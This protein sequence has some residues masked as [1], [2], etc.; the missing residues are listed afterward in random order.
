MTTMTTTET[1]AEE[2]LPRCPKEG[3]GATLNHV[4]GTDVVN[5]NTCGYTGSLAAFRPPVEGDVSRETSEEAVQPDEVLGA[6][7]AKPK[8]EEEPAPAP[9]DQ[10]EAL[11]AATEAALSS[12]GVPGRDEF[13]TLAQTARMLSMSPLVPK[14]LRNNPAAC[15]HLAMIGRDLGISPTSAV[16]LIDVMPEDKNDASK[17]GRP[18]LSPELLNGQVQRTGLGSIV[19]LVRTI[20]RCVAVALAPGGELDRRCAQ[21]GEHLL[22]DD[23]G[24]LLPAELACRCHGILGETE[25]TWEDARVAGL[26][27]PG[28]PNKYGVEREACMPGDHKPYTRTANNRSWTACDCNTGYITY[29]KRM[30]WWRA[31]GFCQ[32]DFLPQASMGLYSPEEMGAVVD[33]KGRMIDP[34]QVAL[35]EGF[36]PEAPPPAPGTEAASDE[37]RQKIADRVAALPDAQAASLKAEWAKEELLG[38]WTKLSVAG[39]K[40]AN[41]LVSRFEAEARREAAHAATEPASGSSGGAPP[42]AQEPADALPPTSPPEGM[43]PDLA[44]QYGKAEPVL[45]DALVDGA[46]GAVHLMTARQVADAL[47]ARVL[48]TEGNPADKSI[49]LAK[50]LAKEAAEQDWT[51]ANAPAS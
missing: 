20:D 42:A 29:P 37:E 31:S 46:A 19:P 25:F 45:T 47:K 10:N 24:V 12:P 43:T 2:E 6:G 7:E 18:M 49:R 36:E 27:Q 15:F 38:P 35:P 16:E 13:L 33:E 51:A 26:V 50:A 11:I 22:F 32:S 8:A 30:L 41:T 1:P 39:V 48:S 4:E 28:T 34:A 23:A 40:R 5:C 44:A 14:F 17:G 21:N 9:V 3:C